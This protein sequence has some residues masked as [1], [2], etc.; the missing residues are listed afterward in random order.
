M[1]ASTS[2]KYVSQIANEFIDIFNNCQ[3]QDLT[4]AQIE[5]YLE[6]GYTEDLNYREDDLER[7][8]QAIEYSI[9]T[10][11]DWLDSG[12]TEAMVKKSVTAIRKEILALCGLETSKKPRDIPIIARTFK[13]PSLMT[14]NVNATSKANR[15]S[16]ETVQVG[17]EIVNGIIDD[18]KTL[19]ANTETIEN[20]SQALDVAIALSLVTGRR[21]YSEIS[22]SAVFVAKTDNTLNFSG[23]AKNVNKVDETYQIYALIDSEMICEKHDLLLDYLLDKPWFE[24]GECTVETIQSRLGRVPSQLLASFSQLLGCEMTPHDL[25]KLYAAMC[26]RLYGT[27]NSF[28][29]FAGQLLGHGKRDFK[30]TYISDSETTNS[31]VKF[32]VI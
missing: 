25:R 28:A 7:Y 19:L 10:V 12:S 26:F 27:S 1:K 18:A 15:A 6:W 14:A 11:Q 22:K 30:G 21:I 17:I 32:K 2:Q 29:N 31:Y 3:T 9:Q 5:T 24:I 20:N 13:A 16:I 23:Q 8:S 4:E